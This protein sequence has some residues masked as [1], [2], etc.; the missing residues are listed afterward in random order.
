MLQKELGSRVSGCGHRIMA[1]TS[2]F[3][4]DDAGSIPAARSRYQTKSPLNR[5]GFL[6]F[7][8]KQALAAGNRRGANGASHSTLCRSGLFLLQLAAEAV[9]FAMDGGDDF[10]GVTHALEVLANAADGDIDGAIVGLQLA[11]CHL[12]E[13]LGTGLDLARVLAEVQHGAEF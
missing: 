2:A 12:L 5:V 10:R 6:F 4:A 13:Q 7:H 9:A 11:A 1:I 8:A 3:Q